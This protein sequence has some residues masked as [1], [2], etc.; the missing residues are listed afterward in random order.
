MA[1]IKGPI[2]GPNLT[3]SPMERAVLEWF[4]K[5]RARAGD[6]NQIRAEL[7]IDQ[8]HGWVDSVVDVGIRAD[9]FPKWKAKADALTLKV[10]ARSLS[11]NSKTGELRGVL[12][13]QDR[14][15]AG[16]PDE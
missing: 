11:V 4:N 5:A 16:K 1:E 13:I 8:E 12:M 2:A 14:I 10:D 9:D 7:I 15:K 6:G 3:L